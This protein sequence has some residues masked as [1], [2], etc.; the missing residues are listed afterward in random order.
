MFDRGTGVQVCMCLALAACEAVA[1]PAIEQARSL[2]DEQLSQTRSIEMLELSVVDQ[3]LEPA[4]EEVAP[5]AASWR[6]PAHEPGRLPGWIRHRTLPGETIEQLALRYG[7]KPESIRE[8][9]ELAADE[10]PH[11]WRPEP[12]R[13]HA[14]RNPPACERLEHVVVAGDT[15]G[16]LSRR[17]GVDYRQLRSRNVGEL[18]R[19]LELGER[20]EIWID[21]IVFDSIVNDAPVSER[22]R[23]VRPGAHGVGVPQ[24]GSL[25][26]GVQI[27]PGKG[28]ELRYPNSAYGTTFAVREAIAALDHFSASSDFPFPL[29]VGTMSRQRG[30]DIGGHLSHQTGRDLDIRLPLREDIPQSLSPTLRR[31]DWATTWELVN[32]FASA[33]EVTVIFLDYTAQRRLY[34]AAQAA[35]AT[36][37]ELDAMLQYPRGS[38]ASLGLIRHSPGHDGHIHVRF[39]CGPAEPECADD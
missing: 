7:V 37:A 3:P 17:Y 13:I 18:G 8:W 1:A 23:L 15:W 21:P 30:G 38:K 19:E 27:P 16:S 33:A 11:E 34:R 25:V 39:P 28:Y 36:E 2:D 22:A 14:R 10:Q 24:A 32:A 26:A 9:N 35:G 31:I 12:L 29:R 5:F 4:L 6:M 20:V